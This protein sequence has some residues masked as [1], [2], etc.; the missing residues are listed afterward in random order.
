M[1]TYNIKLLKNISGLLMINSLCMA[2]TVLNVPDDIPDEKAV[3]LIKRN[4]AEVTDEEIE[5]VE[6]P[7]VR[8]VK[9][10]KK[11]DKDLIMSDLKGK[12]ETGEKVDD[13]KTL[14]NK[15]E[16]LTEDA[17]KELEKTI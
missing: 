10:K 12:E 5:R 11:T 14:A 15:P 3:E 9:S 1:Q 16:R 2:G 17:L 6:E 8:T 13:K 4:I 7:N